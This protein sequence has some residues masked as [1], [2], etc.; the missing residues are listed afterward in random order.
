MFEET[1]VKKAETQ[2]QEIT[3]TTVTTTV[4]ITP[5]VLK[6]KVGETAKTSK[7]EV[8]VV[9]AQ[10]TKLYQ[11]YSTILK[12]TMIE[13]AKPG[14]AFVIADVLIKNVGTNRV[15]VTSGSFSLVDSEGYRY[16]PGL[17]L[18]DDQLEVLKQLYPGEKTRGKILFEVPETAT[19]LKVQYDF[20]NLLTGIKLA[21]WEIEIPSKPTVPPVTT[22]VTTT[23]TEA[24]KPPKIVIH[25]QKKV[26]TA[27]EYFEAT[28]DVY[29]VIHDGKYD[30]HIYE[31][32]FNPEGFQLWR[33]SYDIGRERGF[34]SA[35]FLH[36][37]LYTKHLPSKPGEYTLAVTIHDYITG[38]RT[39][40]RAK[41]TIIS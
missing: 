35:D 36:Y 37:K 2:S 39:T 5:Y 13:E 14:K 40:E 19:G 32:L 38:L 12:E 3:K 6:L 31:E 27:G 9:S 26:Y 24:Y 34:T 22:K 16:D 11:Y 30:I 21:S 15:L 1:P 7:L 23:V 29:N 10:W 25:L 28:Y 20:G 41:F 18:G 17:Y 8:T 33:D 4:T